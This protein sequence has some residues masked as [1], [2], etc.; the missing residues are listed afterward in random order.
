MPASPHFRPALFAFLRELAKNNRR[1]WFQ[2][3]KDRYA[4]SV[5]EPAT[6]FITDFAGELRKLSPHLRADPR[7]VGGS[8]FRIHRDTRFSKDKSPYKTHVGIRFPHEAGKDVHGPTFYLHLQPG[9]VF[10][11]AGVWRPDGASTRKIR[12]AIVEDP[13]AWRRAAHGKR[14]RE[15]FELTGD[16]LKRPPRGYDPEHPLI[17]D[18]MRKDFIGMTRFTQKDVTSPDFLERFTAACRDGM[19]LVKFLSGALGLPI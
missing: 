19:P 15:R 5:R 9:E 14:F 1:D 7:P 3:N 8:L 4:R 6:R 11:G 16:A 12:D 10:A 2:A 17:G 13:A 18:L